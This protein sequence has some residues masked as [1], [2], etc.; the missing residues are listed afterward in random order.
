MEEL[1][2]W[3]SPL[4]F[5]DPTQQSWPAR[6]HHVPQRS[7]C[8][9]RR[10]HLCHG[11]CKGTQGVSLWLSM[12]V[13]GCCYMATR[14]GPR[15]P[16]I[17]TTSWMNFFMR[18]VLL[19]H[20]RNSAGVDGWVMIFWGWF[21]Y[22]FVKCWSL[23]YLF[24]FFKNLHCKFYKL[25]TSQSG[26]WVNLR[27]SLAADCDG[28]QTLNISCWNELSRDSIPLDEWWDPQVW[29]G[30]PRHSQFHTQLMETVG[31]EVTPMII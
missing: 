31:V 17:L 26:D 21:L 2:G 18:P 23:T 20:A 1:P 19:S 3:M 6:M 9:L 13:P 28:K 14:A 27:E 12:W 16:W 11:W 7:I 29:E 25:V 15:S 22:I 10:F 8:I 4:A 24:F 5:R 30:T